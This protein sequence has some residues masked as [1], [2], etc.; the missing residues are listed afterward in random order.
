MGK[1]LAEK[2]SPEVDER[3]AASSFAEEIISIDNAK[4]AGVES[5]NVYSMPVVPMYDY[6]ENSLNEAYGPTT[7]IE[8]SVQRMKI[9]RKRTF[10][11]GIR[12]LDKEMTAMKNE[13]GAFIRRQTDESMM[14][15]YDHYVFSVAANAAIQNGNAQLAVKPTKNNVYEQFLAGM[16]HLGNAKAPL[17]GRIA[18][19]SYGYY[20]LL[21]QCA[22]FIKSGDVSQRMLAKG[23]I[24]MLDGV[25]IMTV[26]SGI[27]PAGF[28]C[29]ITHPYAMTGPKK[30]QEVIV[31][32]NPEGFNGWKIE[33][34]FCYDA[35]VLNNKAAGIY[36]IGA[37]GVNKMLSVITTPSNTRS[38]VTNVT[39]VSPCDY[40][41][42]WKYITGTSAVHTEYGAVPA[43]GFKELE[44]NNV[45]VE[46]GLNHTFIT[47][48]ELDAD[49]KCV[50]EG[51]ARINMA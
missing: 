33:G 22:D 15:D 35:F 24:E 36:Y 1:N 16:E 51:S 45:P 34:M 9:T 18:V 3:F 6:D 41:H 43:D 39:V 11:T 30:L 44:G 21:K 40:G 42:T 10:K 46:P 23:I 13:V 27:L 48:V 12:R 20:G 32:D 28:G 19:M 29:L 25:H 31:H 2:F 14:P 7:I 4:W 17:K 8:R 47:V 37:C 49:G 5:V 26:P 50:G 38:D